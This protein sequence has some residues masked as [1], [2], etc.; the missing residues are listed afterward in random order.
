M[1]TAMAAA[2]ERQLD[3]LLGEVLGGETPF[4]EHRTT[5]QASDATLRSRWFAAALVIAAVGTAFGVALLR[6]EAQDTRPAQEPQETIEWHEAHGPAS[7]TSIPAG[8][9]NLRC[10]DFDDAALQ[11]IPHFAKLE[12]LDLSGRDVNE[13]GYSV[14]LRI[15]DE[16][17]EHLA[18]VPNLRWLSLAGCHEVKGPGLRVLE[19]LPRLEHLDLTY[20]GVETRAVERLP[21]LVS[22]RSLVL[23]HCM[24][25]H[26]RA[27]AEVAKIPGLRRLELRACTTLSAADVMHLAKLS[28]LRHLDLRDCQ[29]RFRGQTIATLDDVTDATDEPESGDPT[30]P[31]KPEPEPPPPPV[32]DGIGIT[33]ASVAALAGL[34]LHGL[35]LGGSESLTDAIGETLAKMT[36]LR[37]LDLSKLPKTTQALLAKV[38]DGLESL[39]LDQNPQF[40]GTMLHQLPKL[41]S[42]R[43]WGLSG[44]PS[45]TAEDL[46]ALLADK[47][48][49]VL[50]LGG[51]M[52][53]GKAAERDGNLTIEALEVVLKNNTMALAS[54]AGAVVAG[55]RELRRLELIDVKSLDAAFLRELAR[56]PQLAELDLRSSSAGSVETMTP[57]ASFRALRSL[58]LMW[59]KNLDLA[60]L[61]ALAGAP[62]RE[63]D[64]Y[65]TNLKPEDIREVGKAWPGCV[66]KMPNGQHWRVQ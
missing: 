65:G 59:C 64:L 35:L 9:V 24:S 21:N 1:T 57:L 33:D 63:L 40:T 15:T 44:L 52:P 48:L 8:V 16:G 23:S 42:L 18:G 12:R 36:T 62:L 55:Q 29:G 11:H 56:L 50:R 31:G 6:D 41:A 20:S 3:W 22:L 27:L 54:G 26:G 60:G 10:F 25:F 2:K 47:S 13:K 4:A 43:E 17:L 51:V 61:K 58:K 34:K 46:R 32:Q 39:A 66:V 7:I 53:M 30:E 5:S 45:I 28:E 37:C 19:A 14:Y 49:H 38:P